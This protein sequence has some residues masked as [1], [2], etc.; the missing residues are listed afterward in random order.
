MSTRFLLRVC[1]CYF[2]V[3]VSVPA[4]P[5][6]QLQ[7]HHRTT[8]DTPFV[9]VSVPAEPACQLPHF[10]VATCF[11]AVTVSVPAE[12][13]CQP[14]SVVGLRSLNLA[15]F[16]CQAQESQLCRALADIGMLRWFQS[17]YPLRGGLLGY[18]PSQGTTLI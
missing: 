2:A 13:A 10:S 15:L 8:L 1:P 11:L 14:S 6:C 5:A 7:L 18:Q 16:C 3:T 17:S 12:P 9:T 4:E